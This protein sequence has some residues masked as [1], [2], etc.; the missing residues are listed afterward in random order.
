MNIRDLKYISAVAQLQHF[1]KAAERCYV[2]QPTLSGQIKKLERQLG[3]QIFERTNRRVMPTDIGLEIIAH[4]RQ[5]LSEIDHITDLAESAQDPLSAKFRLG[6][7]PTLASYIFPDLVS[8]IKDTMPK[9]RLAL[10]EEKTGVLIEK[11]K[12]GQ[13]DAALLAM[14][15]D[16]DFFES[17]KLF[18]DEFMLATPPDHELA[19][20]HPIKPD[21]L[22]GYRLLLL[23][24]GHCLRDQALDVCEH[25][26]IN[27]NQDFRATSLET[28]RQMVKAGSG[29]TFMP[30][31]AIPEND[32]GIHYTPFVKPAP[33]RTIGLYWRKTSAKTKVI[34]NIA[35]LVTSDKL[36]P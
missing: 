31:I 21:T 33:S 23:E 32:M 28:L 30:K 9:L 15:V 6:A 29:I 26:R 10:L 4:A 8:G 24:E 12:S 7:F 14:S 17:T 19:S 25:N 3:V 16:N 34:E 1:G 22:S 36:S 5:I 18:T 27:E 2:S 35:K 20:S 13:I 11:L